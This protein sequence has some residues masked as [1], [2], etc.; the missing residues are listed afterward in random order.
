VPSL[1]EFLREITK[2]VASPG[3]GT[4]YERWKRDEDLGMSRRAPAPGNQAVPDEPHGD[5]DVH[6]GDLGSGSDYTPFLQHFGVPSTDIGSDG[7]FGVY[8][9]VYDN[10]DWFVRFAD[11]TFAYTQQQA[12]VFGL[13]ILH[14]ADADVLPYDYA[15]YA[16]E[17]RGYLE[18]ARSRAV[19]RGMKLDF[20]PALAAAGRFAAAGAAVRAR[21]LAPAKDA[22]GVDLMLDRAL[23]STE[24]ALLIPEGLPR[25]PWYRHSI[26]APGEFTG[27]T[28]A[29]IPGVNEG[30]EAGD[31]ARAQE[32][33]AALARA[34]SRAAGALELVEH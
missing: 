5:G 3:G 25:R 18:Q 21:Q 30:I 27:Y 33:L 19:A 10:Y 23:C 15:T 17:I 14:M 13:E 31:S 34:I 32:Q 24:H 8:H 28:A 26:Y 7:P 6:L 16:E 29:T 12:R 11:P 22:A 2:E 20:G 9:S 1:R 4:V